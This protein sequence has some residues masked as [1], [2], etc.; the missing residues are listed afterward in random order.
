MKT[1]TNLATML[2]VNRITL[3]RWFG[4]YKKGGL[5]LLLNNKYANG[6]RRKIPPD[7]M[8][9]LV[10]RL[11]HANSGFTTYCDVQTWLEEKYGVN[12]SYKV[13]YSTIRYQL[14]LPIHGNAK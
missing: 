9:A 10:Q 5:T 12:V 7:A 11:N 6:R 2:E 8:Q 13:V 4:K 14:N 1:I 3:H